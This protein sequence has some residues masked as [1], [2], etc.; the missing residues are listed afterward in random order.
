MSEINI[1]LNSNLLNFIIV[2]VFLI[3]VIRKANLSTL[4]TQKQNEI[5]ESIKNAEDEKKIKQNH[6]LVTKTKVSNVKQE[7]LKIIDEGEQVASNISESI[8]DDADKQSEDMNK[9]AAAS[10]KNEKQVVSGEVMTKI[11]GAAFYIS[12]EHIK[13]AIDERLHRKYIDEFINNLDSIHN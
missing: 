4:I 6:L 5:V 3:W 8:L 2:I 9:K 11:M 12:E 10:I 13:Q 1:I 7:V